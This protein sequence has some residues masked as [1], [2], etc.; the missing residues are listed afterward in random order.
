MSKKTD[1]TQDFLVGWGVFVINTEVIKVINHAF[2]PYTD[3]F[4][5]WSI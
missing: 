4:V 1:K 5:I 3:M 2:N